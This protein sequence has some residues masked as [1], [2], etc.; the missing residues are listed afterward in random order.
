MK[1]LTSKLPVACEKGRSTL[2]ELIHA[3]VRGA[4]EAAVQAELAP[5][6]G[7]GRL[8]SSRRCHTCRDLRRP[9]LLRRPAHGMLC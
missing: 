2:G 3:A 8:A 9:E 4:I 6:L 5:A 1:K 7:A